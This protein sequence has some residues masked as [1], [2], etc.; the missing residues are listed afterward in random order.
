[1]YPSQQK[2]FKSCSNIEKALFRNYIWSGQ[3]MEKNGEKWVKNRSKYRQWTNSKKVSKLF[4]MRVWQIQKLPTY[5]ATYR[6]KWSQKMVLI[7]TLYLRVC[8]FFVIKP[9]FQFF[10]AQL[11]FFAMWIKGEIAFFLWILHAIIMHFF[12]I[13]DDCGQWVC[14]I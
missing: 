11:E 12:C 1:M 7:V 6:S 3:K 14:M 4:E 5:S 2:L 9:V 13:A 8:T 10:Q